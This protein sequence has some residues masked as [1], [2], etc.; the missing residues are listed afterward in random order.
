M[1][2]TQNPQGDNWHVLVDSLRTVD[3]VA[4]PEVLAALTKVRVRP[5]EAEGYRNAILQGLR[6]PATCGPLAVRLLEHWT[7][8]RLPADGTSN[9][10]HLAAWQAWYADAFP[11][12]LAAELPQDSLHNNKWSFEE[13]ASFLESPDAKAGDPTRGSQVF[14]AAQCV[15]CHRFKGSGENIGPDLTTV[16]Q[17]F[18]QKEILE[19]IVFPSHVVSDQY[20]SHSVLA[21]GRTYVGIVAR[22]PDGSVTVLQSDG[23]KTRIAAEDIEEIEPSKLSAMPDGLLNTLTLE[24]VA[25][26]FALLMEGGNT[27]IARRPAA[28]K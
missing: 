3:G 12:A 26:L 17:R 5:K 19:S 16:S 10:A 27:N 13:L 28:Q 23:G 8:E 11:D 18:Q 22:E 1:S 6:M 15:N 24:Q 9:E 2:L 7:G 14:A 4:A 21:D 20:G 25:D